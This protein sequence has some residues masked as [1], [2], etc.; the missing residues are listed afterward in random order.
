MNIIIMYHSKDTIRPMCQER[1]DSNPKATPMGSNINTDLPHP[2]LKK[3]SY[4]ASHIIM[5]STTRYKIFNM[6]SSRHIVINGYK[7]L[8]H[9]VKEVNIGNKSIA[10]ML[11][12][13]ITYLA[14]IERINLNW[15]QLRPSD[16]I[17]N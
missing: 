6:N 9:T 5:N 1:W 2:L 3:I 16:E 8:M 17:I 13:T 15:S 4:R 14:N 12:S 11:M 10:I 7:I